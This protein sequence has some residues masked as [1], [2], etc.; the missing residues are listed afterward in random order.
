MEGLSCLEPVVVM[1]VE[2]HIIW[3]TNNTNEWLPSFQLRLFLCYSRKANFF[4]SSAI[5][6]V[7]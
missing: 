6:E 2:V 1:L 3:I 7:D 4:L 5:V